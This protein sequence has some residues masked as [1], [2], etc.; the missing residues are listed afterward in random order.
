[1]AEAS[2]AAHRRPPAWLNTVMTFLLRSPLHGLVSKH[3]MLISFTG[4]KSGKTITTPVSRIDAGA[5]YTFFVA[6]PWWR[7]L[8]GGAPVELRIAGRRVPATAT[9]EEDPAVVLAEA[10]AFL[11]ANGAKAG[12]RIGVPLPDAVIPP[13]AALAEILHGRVVVHLKPR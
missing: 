13:D 11:E 9:P 6:S 8:R 7:N 1:M 3:L 2:T 10:R 4:R 5:D 12:F